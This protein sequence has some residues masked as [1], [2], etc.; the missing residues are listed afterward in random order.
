MHIVYERLLHLTIIYLL[1]TLIGKN[2]QTNL[3]HGNFNCKCLT[4]PCENEKQA[5]H[6]TRVRKLFSEF[7]KLKTFGVQRRPGWL[8]QFVTHTS[9]AGARVVT[10]TDKL[11]KITPVCMRAEH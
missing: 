3:P 10:H 7:C 1:L 4:W 9:Y 5:I 2:R 6:V 8:V 11:T